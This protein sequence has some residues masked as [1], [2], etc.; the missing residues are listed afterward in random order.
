MFSLVCVLVIGMA[1]NSEGASLGNLLS[2]LLGKIRHN[3]KSGGSK[4]TRREL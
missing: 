4:N 2:Q 3:S 1:N